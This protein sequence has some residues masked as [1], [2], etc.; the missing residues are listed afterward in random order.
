MNNLI[1]SLEKE[2]LAITKEGLTG[3]GILGKL[4]RVYFNLDKS[5]ACLFI[6]K[7][8]VRWKSNFRG[9]LVYGYRIYDK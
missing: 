7:S 9:L 8:K 2:L 3:K 6:W 4:F 5:N 1:E